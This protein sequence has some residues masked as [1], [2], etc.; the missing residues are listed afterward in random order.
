MKRLAPSLTL[1][2]AACS[3]AC[4]SGPAPAAP[5]PVLARKPY[6]AEQIRDAFPDGSWFRYR[7]VATS[8]S[9]PAGGADQTAYSITTFTGGTAESVTVEKLNTTAD[10]TAVGPPEKSV[11]EWTALRDH[12]AF[13]EE[14]TTITEVELDHPFG[15][16]PCWLYV[17]RGEGEEWRFYFGKELPGPP[18]E[19]EI[20]SGGKVAR[21]VMVGRKSGDVVLGR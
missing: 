20:R 14:R 1:L 10:G 2:L 12:A 6:T 13:P 19:W 8:T 9:A 15:K 5:G 11:A 16:V 21:A 17:V 7:V 3:A 18:I 4:A